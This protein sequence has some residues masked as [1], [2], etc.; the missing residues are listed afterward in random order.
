M[1][2]FRNLTVI[3][4]TLWIASCGAEPAPVASPDTAVTLSVAAPEDAHP[5]I[6]KLHDQGNPRKRLVADPN[7][8]VRQVVVD[9][10]CPADS[11][12]PCGAAATQAAALWLAEHGS[13]WGDYQGE[14]VTDLL[15]NV[16]PEGEFG[17]YALIGAMPT[18]TELRGADMADI[19][20]AFRW[21]GAGEN[22][23]IAVA[24]WCGKSDQRRKTATFCA[25]FFDDECSPTKADPVVK[26]CPR[27]LLRRP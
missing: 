23:E 3:A 27:E 21:N 12:V 1:G 25:A 18:A 9:I 4:A 2:W 11:I 22:G 24:N 19:L 7:A 6:L 17:G 14:P 15:V 20:T 13:E 10:R 5:A 26:A 8:G 16:D